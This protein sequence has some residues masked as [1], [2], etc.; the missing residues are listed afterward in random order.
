[1]HGEKWAELLRTLDALAER[2]QDEAA[3]VEVLVAAA[4][5][6]F[7]RFADAAGSFERLAPLVP[8][9]DTSVDAA[10]TRIAHASGRLDEL[11]DLLERSERWADLV[12]QLETSARAQPQAERAA[13]FLRRAARILHAQ[14][15]DDERAES[16]YH[17]LLALGE[18]GEALRFLQARAL[19]RDDPAALADALSRLARL[20]HEPRELRD[21]WFDYAHVQ[22]ARLAAP[23]AAIPVLQHI[24]TELDPEF[25]PALD[26]LIAAAQ[27]AGDDAVLAHALE[28][29]LQR[30]NDRQGRAELAERLAAL[31]GERL[32]DD[33][34]L[35]R[36]LETWAREDLTDVV[37]RRKLRALLETANQP[38]RLLTTLDEIARLSDSQE[39]RLQAERDAA[40][41]CGSQLQDPE[42]AFERALRLSRTGT[43]WAEDL[44]RGFA[45]QA[46]RLADLTQ[47]YADAERHDEVVGL[48]RQRALREAEPER[49]AELLLSAA[50]TLAERVGDELAAAEV[51][52]E[53]LEV[54]EDSEALD[55]L[56]YIA[57][58]N[59]DAALLADLLQR[60]AA[61]S[62][63]PEARRDLLLY[64]AEL[65]GDELE[66]PAAAIA[67]LREVLGLDP[68]SELAA[69]ALVEIAGRSGDH[70]ALCLGLETKLALARGPS[71][72]HA[73]SMRLADLY[74]RELH[75]PDRA[76]QALRSA[77]Q[78]EPENLEA[79]RR[80]RGH[81]ERQR[82]H[83]ELVQTLDVLSR[84]EDTQSAR[85]DARLAA[86]RCLFEQLADPH[87][88][89][90]RLAPLIQAAD[91]EAEELAELVCRPALAR[92]LAGVYITRAKQTQ[93][94]ELLRISWRKVAH[95]HEHWL[96]EPAE[97]FEASLRLLASDTHD[98]EF[99]DEV[100]RLAK[101][102][103]SF[104]RLSQVYAKLVR[105]AD[106][107][108]ARSKLLLRLAAILENEASEP[109]QALEQLMAASRLDPSDAGLIERIER[110]A[111]TLDSHTELLWAKE[112]KALNATTP[113]AEIDALL[114]VARTADLKLHDREHATAM[115]RR[116]LELVESEQEA[117]ERV[118]RVA[119]EL[120][121]AR[122]ELGKEDA[123]RG[124]LRAHLSLA[125]SASSERRAE[126]VLRAYRWM[127]EVLRDTAAGFDLLRVGSAEPPISEPLLD[128]LESAAT[129][130]GRLD[131]LNAHLARVAERADPDH[132]RALLRRRA[133]IL[134]ERL[135]RFDQAAQAYERLL[136]IDP[137]DLAVEARHFAS[138]K[139]AGRYR[140]LLA[141][142]E[143]RLR[144]SSDV[145]RRTALMR[146][147]A[148][149]WEVDL[150]NRASAA[151]V[152]N[153][154]QALV[155]QDP[156][157]VAAIARLSP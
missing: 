80:L 108:A 25:E 123:Q 84:I 126:L 35:L 113:A 152:W 134:E 125:E 111:E 41:L 141:A 15:R 22:H 148:R 78:N 146:E 103:L 140:E 138:L 131:A 132:K 37:P 50:R 12:E 28:R 116:A 68:R 69:S 100:D 130:L 74:E 65:L 107:D 36:A 32:H 56:R 2:E 47:Y 58:R 51:Y 86:A 62:A 150:K 102:T 16:A 73:L 43:L 157:A 104:A 93:D 67:L 49:R 129:G 117:H 136:E 7:E 33:A 79:Q 45:W 18:D 77:C 4:V 55:Y 119:A 109:A 101:K 144:R 38:A 13:Q 83:A 60:L 96:S 94:S 31:Y 40:T 3:R 42:Q 154:V 48:L 5:L 29:Q 122:P 82:A 114:E 147:I 118:M 143:R 11:F 10:L 52:R 72:H 105:D 59:D 21:L 155:P 39:E 90:L 112:Q 139:Q 75:D 110:L 151:M 53:V 63:E 149:V 124:L 26:E 89:L 128:A 135:K 64:R 66:Q 99:L 98:P 57:E 120:D 121:A 27:A 24:L 9:E 133:R 20:P 54:R 95:I 34:A 97:A 92:E 14:L 91:A 17:R 106:D 137:D 44:L 85:D 115:L 19:E 46:G 145:E 61:L 6:A 71:E 153:E 23:S 30:E 87:A 88:A 142:L 1:Q 70:A 8:L 127:S 81:L 156:E 76:A